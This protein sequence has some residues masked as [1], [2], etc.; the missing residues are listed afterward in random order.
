MTKSSPATVSVVCRLSIGFGLFDCLS[1]CLLVFCFS[2]RC[3]WP[4]KILY[5]ELDQWR[6][7]E[8]KRIKL[9]EEGQSRKL[10]LQELL[11][12]ETRLLQT[13]DRLKMKAAH[14]GKVCADGASPKDGTRTRKSEK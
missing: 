9:A 4:R 3:P 7:A 8:T 14:G 2:S 5:S 11:H 12:K 13:I 6:E 1:V 10:A